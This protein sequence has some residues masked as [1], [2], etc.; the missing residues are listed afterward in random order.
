MTTLRKRTVNTSPE[1]HEMQRETK[2]KSHGAVGK[3]L[4]WGTAGLLIYGY[5]TG[6]EDVSQLADPDLFITEIMFAVALG[7]AFVLRFAWMRWVNGS[8]RLLPS[9]PKWERL[10]SKVAHYGIYVG[11]AAIVLSGLAIAY[12]YATPGLDGF[13][14]TAMTA[15]H[16]FS[17]HV[18][19]FLLIA[20]VLGAVWHKLVRR[21]GIWESMLPKWRGSSKPGHEP[22]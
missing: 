13:F 10:L 16:E 5:F 18:T 7:L 9:A 2:V 8:T 1:N 21:D 14:V 11:V 12:G 6:V 15:V 22:A 4:H 3:L 20:H 19:A 17:L